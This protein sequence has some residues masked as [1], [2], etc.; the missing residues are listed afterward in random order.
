MAAGPYLM[1]DVLGRSALEFSLWF[2]LL[3]FTFMGANLAAG[4]ISA[5]VGTRPHG[6]ARQSLLSLSRWR[7]LLVSH[8]QRCS[9]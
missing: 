3:T 4:R 5:R 9:A 7:V 6:L 2:A 8:P 1:V